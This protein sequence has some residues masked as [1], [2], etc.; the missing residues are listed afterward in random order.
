[1][2]VVL[3]AS[4]VHA[5]S[6]SKPLPPDQIRHRLMAG[7]KSWGYQLHRADVDHIA[8]SPFDLVVVD[9]ARTRAEQ[10][11]I[12]FTAD[13]VK[14]MQTRPDGG[15]RIVLAYLS[16]GEAEWYR[17]YWD[18]AWLDA[19]RP[20]WLGEMNP[21][22]YGNFPVRFWDP[23][24]QS[25]ILGEPDGYLMRILSAG[26]DGVYLDRADVYQDWS[27]EHPAARSEMV[28]F[29]T[30]LAAI[31][32]Q[33]RPEFLVVQQNAE[34]LLENGRL[35]T[36]I[37][38]VAKESLI[39]GVDAPEQRNKNEEIVWSMDMLKLA[40]KAGHRVMVIEYLDDPK[41]AADA[42][43]RIERAGFIVTFGPRMLH[44]LDYEPVD[45]RAERLT[46]S[47]PPNPHGPLDRREP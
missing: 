28:E 42:R 33:H 43:T 37:D 9:Y 46:R 6:G 2:A 17:Y 3:S 39:Y 44:E 26:F 25:I 29:V 40:A 22:W 30:R 15:R 5:E 18:S 34:E 38:G 1:M 36:L 24:W 11:E 35:R 45:R 12:P 7:V 10:R 20:S 14:R 32:R 16:F 21:Q 4:L 27:G 19:E 8:N 31:A 23:R 47:S 13:E 41:L